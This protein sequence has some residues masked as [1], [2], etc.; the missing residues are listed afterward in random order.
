MKTPSKDQDVIR[1]CT[2][3]GLMTDE[4]INDEMM[5]IK[6]HQRNSGKTYSSATLSNMNLL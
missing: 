1:C 5:I 3:P 4:Y 2:P 6:E